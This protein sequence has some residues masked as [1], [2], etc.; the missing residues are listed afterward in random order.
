[1]GELYW[2]YEKYV[3]K[4]LEI[5]STHKYVLWKYDIKTNTRQM[6][7]FLVLCDVCRRFIEKLDKVEEQLN[8]WLKKN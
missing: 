5:Y 7:F 8:S 1:M 2:R 4:I 6:R 3:G